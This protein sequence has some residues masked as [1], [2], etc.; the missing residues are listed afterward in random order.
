M[1]VIITVAG[2]NAAGKGTIVERL[3]DKHGFKSY[4][5]RDFFTQKMKEEG[6]DLSAGRLAITEFANK[7]RREKGGDYIAKELLAYA[8]SQGG[9]A[10]LESIRAPI[11][12]D[13]FSNQPGTFLF[14]IDAPIEVRHARALER[15]SETEK[16]GLTFER[17][18]Y[19]ENVENSSTNPLE[20]N[21]KYC[22]EKAPEKFRFYNNGTISE[23]CEKIDAVMQKILVS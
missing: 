1:S 9:N 6:V 8:R 23:L 15:K 10:V 3:V 13:F 19:E 2:M 22:F 14:A 11:E 5:F 17:F 21:L 7:L 20:Q 12:A 16:T 4:S 18:V